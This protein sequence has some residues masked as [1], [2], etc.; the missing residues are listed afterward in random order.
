M[1]GDERRWW[2]GEGSKM[3]GV[4]EGTRVVA[5]KSSSVNGIK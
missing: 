3:R 5:V 2:C 4:Q 1:V